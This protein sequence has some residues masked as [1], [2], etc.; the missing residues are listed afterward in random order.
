MR[1]RSLPLLVLLIAA[2][3][4]DSGVEPVSVPEAATVVAADSIDGLFDWFR[5]NSGVEHRARYV[6]ADAGAWTTLWQEIT[7]KIGPPMPVPGVDFDRYTVIVAS[8][9]IRHQ[10]GFQILIESVHQ[11]G[12][13][14]YVVVDERS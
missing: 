8:M 4:G 10:G 3:C 5:S 7:R 14:M 12:D 11:L 9:G 2:A 1:A 13:D 6:V